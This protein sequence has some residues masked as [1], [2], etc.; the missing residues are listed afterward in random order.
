ML[1]KPANQY[2]SNEIRYR[3]VGSLHS[4]DPKKKDRQSVLHCTSAFQLQPV[5]DNELQSTNHLSSQGR[6]SESITHASA[7]NSWLLRIKFIN[8]IEGSL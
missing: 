1:H 5:P 7:H 4:P 8:E 6:G 3:R 2:F